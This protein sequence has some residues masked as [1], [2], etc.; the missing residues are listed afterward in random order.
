M[1]KLTITM[2]LCLV[3]MISATADPI[4]REQARQ[5]A[6]A[7]L[8]KQN[9]SRQLKAVTSARRLAPKKNG[10]GTDPYYVFERDNAEGFVIVSGDDQ[11]IDVLGYTDSG[12]FD[13]EQLPPQLQG[14]L[15]NYARQIAAIQAGAPVQ[16]LPAN[17]PKVE[18][19]LF[20]KW[21]QGDPY[22]QLCPLDGGSRSVTGCVATAMAQILYYNR[23]KS[24]TETTADIPGFTTYTKQISVPGIAAG[25]PI[26]WDNMKDTYSSASDRQKQ[27]VAQLMLY[28][29]VSVQMDYT[30]SSSGAQIYMVADACKKYFGYGNSVKFINEFSSEDEIDQLVYTELAAGRPVYLGGYT[31]DWSMGHAFLTCGYENQRYYI[32]WGWGGQSDGFYYLTNLTP[33]DGQGIGGSDDGYSTGRSIIIGF[34]PENFGEKAMSFSDTAVKKICL[35]KWDADGDGKLTYNEAAAVTDLGDA[36]KGNTTIKKFPEL[37][38]FT[39]LTTLTDD[40]FNG[41]VNLNS[42]RLPK[43]LK[44]IGARAFMDC[45]KLPQINLPTGINAIGE[46]AFAGC[47]LLSELELSS[48]LTVIEKGLFKNCSGLTN[49]NL[50]I[51]VNSIGDEAFASCTKLNSF[52][53]NTYHPEDIQLGNAV[54]DNV[55]LS[56]A[57]LH[58]MQGTKSFFETADQWKDF[59]I[60]VQTR[61][62]SGGQFTTLEAGNTY[63]LYNIGTG[64]YL[65]KGEAYKTQAVVGSEP[66]RFKAVHPSSKPEGVYYFTSPDTGKDGKYLFR[67]S[68][69]SNVGKGVKAVFVDG[70]A[71]TNGYWSVQQVGDLIYT[72]Q[73]PSTESTYVE[74]EFLGVQT[75]HASEAA[76]PTY[77]AYYDVDYATHQKNCQW[78]LVLYDEARTELYNEAV[79]LE[80]L[81]STAKKRNVKYAEEQAVFDNLD[82]K[83]EEL[84]AA[85]S[86]L[87]KKLKFIDFSNKN[88]RNKMIELFD[89]DIDGELS[90]KEASDV[91]DFGWMYYF[92]DDK[93]IVTFDELQYFTHAQSIP[94]NFLQGCINLESV[95]VPEGVEKIYYYAFK[96]CKKLKSINIPEYVN[97]IGEEAFEGCSALREVTI[98]NPNP[99]NIALENNIFKNVPLDKCTLYVPFGSKALYEENPVFNQFGSI[100]EIRTGHTTPTFSPIITDKRGYIYHIGTRQMVS[101][102][103][104]YGTQSIVAQKGRLYQWKHTDKMGENVYYLMDN[105]TEKVIFRTSTDTNVGD[106]VKACF[107]D[108]NLSD[109][110]YWKVVS[111]D[112]NIYTLQVPESDASYVENEYVGINENHK[113]NVASPTHGLYWDVENVSINT[114]WAFVTEEDY[115]NAQATDDIVAKLKKSL[116]TAKA[117]EIDVTEEQAVYDNPQSTLTELTDAFDSVRAKLHT[118][119][120]SDTKV[121]AI[122]LENWD[123][124]GDD[125]LTY[126]EAQ[127]VTNISD[128]FTGSGIETF[129]EFKYFTS[130]TEIPENAF[131]NASDLKILYLPASVKKIGDYAFSGCTELLDYVILNDTEVI[132]CGSCGILP[133][134]T[135]FLPKNILAAY[136]ADEVWTEKVKRM[137]EY[138]GKPVVTAEA[139]RIYGRTYA[140]ISAFVVGAPV[141]GT[142]EAECDLIAIGTTPVGTYPMKVSLGTITDPNVELREGVLT[143]TPATLKCSAKSYSREVGQPNPAFEWSISGFRNKESVNV[144]IKMPTLKCEANINSPA[145]EYPIVISGGEAQNYVFEYENGILTITDPVGIKSVEADDDNA[146]LYDMQGRRID[147][148]K[149][150]L[151]VKGNK[152]VV[153]K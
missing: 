91:T 109:K 68:T 149:K 9:D 112:S 128:V 11:T 25:A 96:G 115:K 20:C 137:T 29:G 90:Y 147:N 132:P 104:A 32:N 79:T 7:F 88:I 52:T 48:E 107:G 33:G 64:R 4:T 23:E 143:I 113:S 116:A 41:C 58:V 120:F 131:R 8:L 49:F 135:L 78:Q 43:A 122:C 97:V 69:D 44:T 129:E 21:S 17:H 22:N 10:V 108:G 45:R 81:I 2:L 114:E 35:A 98:S 28:C 72:I 148:P 60:V 18:Q 63:Y 59:G 134:S 73:V 106:G 139:T 152:K 95:I 121:Q 144:L 151:Y 125:E 77:G 14:L 80:K 57:T 133:K 74:G 3:C 105:A 101:M 141:I 84:Q 146:V 118:I 19:F 145:G 38:Y 56:K 102:G 153:I 86:S 13:Y 126:E 83:I 99:A 66:M 82:S 89:G 50:P 47:I 15:E 36:F 27:A 1:K 46:N 75:D 136:E 110:A 123:A 67:T 119:T 124:D 87:R 93:T 12:T 53:I 70:T 150:G 39:S 54:F 117:K 94:G 24:V 130:V 5:K 40:A 62:I 76:A 92:L 85:Q 6:Q 16:K 26:D 55:N 65:T 142:P 103:E 127:A 100:V 34:E 31:G 51:N 42:L 140:A 61:D 138:T 37:Y 30:N 111:V 71:L